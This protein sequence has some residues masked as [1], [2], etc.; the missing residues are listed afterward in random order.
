MIFEE[1]VTLLNEV[2]VEAQ[3]LGLIPNAEAIPVEKLREALSEDNDALK[4]VELFASKI[5]RI[6]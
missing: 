4:V 5:T 1:L 3:A 2:A 6:T